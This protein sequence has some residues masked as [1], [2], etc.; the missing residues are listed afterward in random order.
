MPPVPPLRGCGAL[1]STHDPHF[2]SERGGLVRRVEDALDVHRLL[3]THERLRLA[4]RDREEVGD[5]QDVGAVLRQVGLNHPAPIKL[6]G[7]GLL[8][9]PSVFIWPKLAVHS[10]DPWPKAIVYPARGTASLWEP[11][12]VT[13]GAL[14]D[15]VGRSRAMLLLALADPASTTQLAHTTGLAIGSVGDHLR[16]LEKAGLLSSAR[17]GRSVLYRRTPLGDVIAGI[18]T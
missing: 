10:D 14:A 7:A 15:L 12:A 1:R 8:F 17:S 16:L 5:L 9:I 11:P 13:S 6:G 2:A 18:G 3:L 4:A